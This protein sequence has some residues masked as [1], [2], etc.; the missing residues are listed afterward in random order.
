[1]SEQYAILEL[2]VSLGPAVS[3]EKITWLGSPTKLI[4]SWSLHSLYQYVMR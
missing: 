4:Q 2:D 1:M 3:W